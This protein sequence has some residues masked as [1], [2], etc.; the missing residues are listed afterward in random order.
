ML[1]PVLARRIQVVAFN[2]EGVL[3]DGSVYFGALNGEPFEMKRFSSQDGVAVVLLRDAG[4][5]VV[6]LSGRQSEATRLRMAALGVHEFIEDAR[7]RTLPAFEATLTTFGAR[8]EDVAY[9]GDDL[10]DL[11]LLRRVGF[12]VAVPNAVAEVKELARVTTE[13]AGGSGAVREFAELLLRA[14]GQW[15]DVLQAYLTERGDPQPRHTRVR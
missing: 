4:L 13:A 3:T 5:K 2:V 8:L 10:A 1:E 15:D 6:A 14:R 12:P 9:I 7:G 11:P